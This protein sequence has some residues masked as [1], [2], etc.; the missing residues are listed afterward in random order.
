MENLFA[1]L[2]GLVPGS[3]VLDVRFLT[4]PAEVADQNVD[5]I[6]RALAECLRDARPDDIASLS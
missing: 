2:R 6:D 1:A 4:N 5:E 3:E